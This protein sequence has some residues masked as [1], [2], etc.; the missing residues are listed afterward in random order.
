M[1]FYF[2]SAYRNLWRNPLFSLIN[3]FGLSVGIACSLL[4]LLY[5]AN[6]F[7]YEHHFP[8]YENI[9]R[10]GI[11][12]KSNKETQNLAACEPHVASTLAKFFPDVQVVTRVLPTE[13]TIIETSQKTR[14]S[15]YVFFADSSYLEFLN[16][17]FYM[18]IP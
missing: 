9:Y 14:Y 1:K 3:I 12:Y 13:G 2:L 6:E 16:I 5:L 4:I 11:K 8:N 18:E 7:T 15:Q 17:F 10:L